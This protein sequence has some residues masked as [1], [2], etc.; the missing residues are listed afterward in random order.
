MRPS[1]PKSYIAKVVIK[2][3]LHNNVLSDILFSMDTV[4]ISRLA[5]QTLVQKQTRTAEDL[6]SLK[7]MVV[8]L[9]KDEVTSQ[10]AKKLEKRSRALDAGKGKRFSTMRS[11]KSYLKT[12]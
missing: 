1:A 12:L 6:L 9:A 2:M 4:T 8:L 5:Y 11:F 10:Y 7:K 3:K